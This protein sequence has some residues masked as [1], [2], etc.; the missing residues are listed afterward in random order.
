MP[1]VTGSLTLTTKGHTDIHDITGEVTRLVEQSG[2]RSG[3]AT[4]FCPSTRREF[5]EFAR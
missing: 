3:T 1:I 2:L 5:M 4:V